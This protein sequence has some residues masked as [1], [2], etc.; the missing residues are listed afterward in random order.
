MKRAI[1]VWSESL[2]PL[3]EWI[4]ATSTGYRFFVLVEII[5][6]EVLVESI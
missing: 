3:I 1:L 4:Y 6:F 2:L 5:Q